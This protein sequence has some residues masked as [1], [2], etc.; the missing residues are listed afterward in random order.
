MKTYTGKSIDEILE[1]IATQED[2]DI[3]DITYKIL[4]EK[5]G[6]L[7]VGKEI[8]VEAFT[9]RDI[10]DFVYDYILQF[11]DNMEMEIE[12]SVEEEDDNFYKATINARNNAILIGK[13]GQTLQAMNTVLKA[14]V[15]GTF[16]K[17]IST[18]V[19]IN[20]YKEERYRK[21]VSIATRV[22]KSVQQT[23]TDA[24]LDPMPN[25]ERKAIHNHLSTFDHI[26]TVSEG[27][28]NQ[29]RLKIC[30]SED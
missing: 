24:V 4:E 29:R 30:Y 17:R 7:G 1:T 19:D 20:G 9:K 6:F 8:T 13:N 14:A 16:K 25:D 11:F 10:L 5:A 18:L 3:E 2:V 22:A 23:K 26:T 15:S 27:D 12:L 28:G 21:V